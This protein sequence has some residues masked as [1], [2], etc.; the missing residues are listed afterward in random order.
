MTTDIERFIAKLCIDHGEAGCW[1][2]MG[3]KD[4][5][6]YGRFRTAGE[7]RAHRWSFAAFRGPIPTGMVI[8][9]ICRQRDCVNPAHLRAV[10]SG[11]NTHAQNSIAPAKLL[12]EAAQ[13]VHGHPFD[14]VNTLYT[15]RGYRYCRECHLARS[16]KARAKARQTE[17]PQGHQKVPM[18]D[19]RMY[20]PICHA[21]ARR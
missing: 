20:C 14:E 16:R 5:S 13:C 15:K 19:G 3:Y 18:S 21:A 12:K 17:C 4:P 7:F 10:T 11:E 6:G 8:D 1:H 9:H 2:W